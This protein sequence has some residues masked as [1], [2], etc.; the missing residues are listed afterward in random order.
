MVVWLSGLCSDMETSCLRFEGLRTN[1][2][3]PDP[4]AKCSAD[5]VR[6]VSYAW[7]DVDS[8]DVQDSEGGPI[9]SANW[10]ADRR[11]GNHPQSAASAPAIVK[12]CEDGWGQAAAAHGIH[13]RCRSAGRTLRSGD[14][15]EN[16]DKDEEQGVVRRVRAVEVGATA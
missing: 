11:L 16:K 6:L 9:V 2:G 14:A 3:G 1:A 10:E 13:C 7:L 12:T 8:N 15:P 4:G 5:W